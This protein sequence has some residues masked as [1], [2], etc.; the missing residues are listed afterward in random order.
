MNLF[1]II[2]FNIE[3]LLGLTEKKTCVE[4]LGYLSLQIILT[5]IDT[6][7]PPLAE[8]CANTLFSQPKRRK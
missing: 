4:A 3:R 5:D 2:I 6:L 1:F 8:K 7:G